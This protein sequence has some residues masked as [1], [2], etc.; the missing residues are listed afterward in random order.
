MSCQNE[1][2]LE[3]N[4]TFS[5]NTHDILANAGAADATGSPSYRIYE[6]ETATPLL[7]GSMA[8]LDDANTTGFYTEQVACTAANGFEQNKTYNIYIEATV[9]GIQG[10]INYTFTIV[11]SVVS[12]N[13]GSNFT[14]T[15]TTH[16]T[17]ASSAL[18]DADAVPS[19]RVYEDETAT[20]ILN[21]N[22][23]KLDDANTLG[24]YSE[25][26]ACTTGNGFEAGKSYT[27]YISATVN[28]IVG[29]RS[30]SFTIADMSAPTFAGITQL[31]AIGG[32]MLKASWAAGSGTIT[33]YKL[34]IQATTATG[35]FAAGN[36][37]PVPAGVTSWQVRSLAN[38]TLLTNAATYFVGVRADNNGTTDT[39]TVSLSAAPT[40]DGTV[41]LST[42]DFIIN[43]QV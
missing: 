19:Y 36:L 29:T 39:N 34:Y 1:V 43:K 10:G 32:G 8:K 31:Q 15:A 11:A 21:G 25:Q 24:F 14:F 12:V 27:V 30:Y 42:P 23:A 4:L 3:N 6:D 20:P 5:I 2:V 13:I 9:N 17:T 16:D 18:A 38:N 26:I 33:G 7:T 28:S 35:L 40:G 41:A 37:I 22:M